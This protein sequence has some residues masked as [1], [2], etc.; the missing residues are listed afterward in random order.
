MQDTP[1]RLGLIGLGLIGTALARRLIG[2]GFAVTGYDISAEARGRLAGIGGTPAETIGEIARAC[3]RVL[4][5]VF[6][7]E[8]VEGVIEGE[9][10]LLSVP[11]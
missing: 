7:T 6:N 9:G 2:A 5:A 10:G 4:I 1:S 3:P 8:Q 11:A